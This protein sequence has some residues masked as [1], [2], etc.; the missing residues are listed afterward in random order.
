MLSRHRGERVADRRAVGKLFHMTGKYN[1]DSHHHTHFLWVK[2]YSWSE[3][4]IM[5]RVSRVMVRARF[6]CRLNIVVG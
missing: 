5:V 4:Q 1:T 6:M 3:N 2:S